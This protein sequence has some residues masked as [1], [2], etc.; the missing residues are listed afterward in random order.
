MMD[1]VRF[2]TTI[3]RITEGSQLD[4]SCVAAELQFLLED[5]EL[6]EDLAEQ[7]LEG[8]LATMVLPSSFIRAVPCRSC[9]HGGGELHYHALPF[10][11]VQMTKY[12][13]S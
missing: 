9:G 2:T 1:A 13:H 7:V 5:C 4:R 10:F 12:A 3:A 11:S 8:C 6:S